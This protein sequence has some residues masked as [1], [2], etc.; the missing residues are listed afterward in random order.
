MKKSCSGGG[1]SSSPTRSNLDLRAPYSS[2]AAALS[3]LSCHRV[4][5]SKN[6]RLFIEKGGEAG[7]TDVNV[8]NA[9]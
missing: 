2:P 3:C 8:M 9:T 1:A 7:V 5:S 6:P 4:H